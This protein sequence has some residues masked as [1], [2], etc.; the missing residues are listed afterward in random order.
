MCYFNVWL[1]SKPCSPKAPEAP[2]P[3]YQRHGVGEILP[4]G[5]GSRTSAQPKPP[6]GLSSYYLIAEVWVIIII[7]MI[8]MIIM[9]IT[10][11]CVILMCNFAQS[12]APQMHQRRPVH[13]TR[14]TGW[15]KSMR[16]CCWLV[17]CWCDSVLQV[18]CWCAAGV[19]AS[20]L[21]VCCR[22]AAS[23]LQVCCR[24]A[25]GVLLVCC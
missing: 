9:I 23:V 14:G 18:C 13:G 8:V 4:D 1:C 25:A 24:C 21:Q 20:V 10:S 22:C 15:V 5:K 17:C 2:R 3:R 7:I 19:C 16:V 11:S 12:P 6:E